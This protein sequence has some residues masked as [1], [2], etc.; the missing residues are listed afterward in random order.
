MIKCPVEDNSFQ[1]YYSYIVRTNQ[2]DQFKLYLDS[3]GIETKIHYPILMPFH[4]AYKDH[5]SE[6]DLPVAKR[7]VKEILSIPNHEGMSDN[8]IQYVAQC[9][10]DF[11]PS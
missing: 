2:R 11:G 7:V 4:S 6:C 8:E 5:Y 1:V 9:I 10:K 3:R